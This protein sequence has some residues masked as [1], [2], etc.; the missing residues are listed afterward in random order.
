MI[1]FLLSIAIALASTVIRP[2]TARC[3]RGWWLS[4]GVRPDGRFTCT[5]DALTDDTDTAPRGHPT[6]PSI[7]SRV[8]CSSGASPRV[9]GVRVWCAAGRPTS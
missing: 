1:A 5:L 9:D 6:R 7:D 4:H 3:P 8:W 2:T